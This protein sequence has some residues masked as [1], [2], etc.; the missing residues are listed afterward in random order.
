MDHPKDK[1]GASRR[2]LLGGLAAGAIMP[3]GGAAWAQAGFDWRKFAGQSIAVSLVKNPRADLLAK[4]TPE[5]EALTGIKAEMELIPEQQHRQKQLIEFVSGKPSFD[6]TTVSWHVQK[7]QFGKGRWLEDLRPMLAD[8]SLTAADFD[9]KDFS[10]GALAFGT[11]ADGRVDSLPLSLDYLLIYYNKEMFEAKGVAFPKTYEEMVQAAAKLT[12]PG[13]RQYGWV[14]RG[15]K[16]ANTYVWAALMLGWGEDAI[17]SNGEL[18]TAGPAAIESAKMFADL[19]RNSAPPGTIGY[20]WNEC[21]TSFMQG[22]AAMW[23]DSSGFA[24]PLEDPSKSRIVGKVGYGVV[25]R[26][27]GA[28]AVGLTGDGIGVT[29]ASTKKGPAY[30]YVQWATSKL[31]HGRFLQNG[32]GAGARDS[33]YSDPK[34]LAEVKTSKDWVS[35]IQASAPLGRPALPNIIPVTEFRDV[36]GVA[37]TNMI[38]GADPATELRKATEA[39][40]PTL[41]A[42]ER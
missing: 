36:F 15:L 40:K 11:Q 4:Y 41:E 18:N 27:P 3:T 17:K 24:T 34:V 20:N 10:A 28:Q 19:C 37:L 8:A 29:A 9:F 16:N 21:Q 33:I 39:F 35:G 42:S 6:V 2:E 12:D 25:P 31:N 23:P 30:L 22:G 38:S 5:F 14:A 32:A 26:G 7:R 1:A 13:K